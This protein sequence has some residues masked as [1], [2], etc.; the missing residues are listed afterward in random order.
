M[1]SINLNNLSFFGYHGLYEEERV[2][3]N[4]FI[5]NATVKFTPQETITTIAQTIDYSSVYELIK[6]R[7]SIPT[8]LL[9]TI[10]MEIAEA[11]LKDFSMAEEIHITLTKENP[12]IADFRGSVGV[13]YSLKRN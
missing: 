6:Q 10:V 1:L 13:S 9:E 3:G 4:T 8:F 2:N 11:V 12:P 7:M 5:V